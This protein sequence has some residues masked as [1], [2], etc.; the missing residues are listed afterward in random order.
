MFDWKKI[1]RR[2]SGQRNSPKP[3]QRRSLHN[4][5]EFELLERREMFAVNVFAD[6]NSV[7]NSSFPTQITEIPSMATGGIAFSAETSKGWTLVTEDVSSNRR[8]HMFNGSELAPMEIAHVRDTSGQDWV[9]FSGID[10]NGDREL[11]RLK[12]GTGQINRVHN[13]NPNGSSEPR[14]LTAVN[15][16]LYFSA[17]NPAS[18]R[19]LWMT[20]ADTGETKLVVDLKPG[21]NASSNPREL[22]KFQNRIFFV[23][24]STNHGSQVFSSNGLSWNLVANIGGSA[25]SNPTGLTPSGNFLY[26]AATSPVWGREVWKSGGT[27]Q[28]TTVLADLVPNA[29]S[30]N[31][32]EL[33]AWNGG[34]AFTAQK[35][36][37]GRELYRYEASV[38]N[39]TF[40]LKDIFPGS[41]GSN[42]T[43]LTV[44][45]GVL[46]FSANSP[47]Y[48]R[49]LW[50]SNGISANTVMVK[51]LNSGSSSPQNL[52]AAGGRVYFSAEHPSLGRELYRSDGTAE[53]T[54]I[55]RDIRLG[56]ASS[57]PNNFAVANSRFF[58][59]A[60]NALG[61]EELWYSW[62][63]ATST[64][65]LDIFPGTR[66][67]APYH[68]TKFGERVAFFSN[69]QAVTQLYVTSGPG[70]TGTITSVAS[71]DAN[72]RIDGSS[73]T[74]AG[75]NFFFMKKSLTGADRVQ[76]WKSDGTT[77][78]TIMVKEI[79]GT[80]QPGEL[81]KKTVSNETGTVL[82]MF[83]QTQPG[84]YKLWKS[85][86]TSGGTSQ[87]SS[88]TDFQQ[89]S[90]LTD[91]NGRLYFVSTVNNVSQLW[92]SIGTNATTVSIPNLVKPNSFT[93]KGDQIYFF[94][95]SGTTS[96]FYRINMTNAPVLIRSNIVG[97]GPGVNLNGM[98]Y[99]SARDGA[100][101]AFRVWRSNGTSEVFVLVKPTGVT[102]PT[103]FRIAG[104]KV[105]FT[106]RYNTINPPAVMV[107]DGTSAGTITLASFSPGFQATFVGT[108][109]NDLIYM[110][111]NYTNGFKAVRTNGT[112]AGTLH[113]GEINNR[114]TS[115]ENF[116][117]A[118]V[119]GSTLYFT[120]IDVTY[121]WE[122]FSWKP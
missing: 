102:E 14:E 86:G 64:Q 1:L 98:M 38:L 49:E 47:L 9:Y 23:A 8:I 40:M 4:K 109:G 115:L 62:G 53:T 42:P 74:S 46:F 15:D 30:S 122:L 45:N 2:N 73:L 36:A 12:W 22:T 68:L 60:T 94:A 91:V 48:G 16:R 17:W 121:G 75:S 110:W 31:P 90:N 21:L 63:S 117:D 103:N 76:L 96:N 70:L 59:S 108:V 66:G 19:E 56:G 85:D 20:D 97:N 107:T 67:S 32:E 112:L 116:Y 72:F 83:L 69:H 11:Y 84:I 34:L 50:K 79:L 99:F 101:T 111:G 119:I 78:G 100:D 26:F 27:P 6:L 18:G 118:V 88:S 43:E 71:D 77:A 92:R 28:T 10:A 29:G 113:I 5:L 35:S 24:D 87:L 41:E 25:G 106:A 44:A 81:L 93:V 80:L 82:Y 120:A 54:F 3:R 105:F 95:Q 33:T 7:P 57:F 52:I 37:S 61:D 39:T 89:V 51:D 55:A 13:V 58:F 104:G 114:F 65:M